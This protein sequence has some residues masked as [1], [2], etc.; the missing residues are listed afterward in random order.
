MAYL[1]T[2]QN[3]QARLCE[4]ELALKEKEPELDLYN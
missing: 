3:G 4:S 1:E 2:K